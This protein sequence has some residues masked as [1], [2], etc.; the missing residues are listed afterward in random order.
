MLARGGGQR[1][2]C[3]QIEGGGQNFSLS[4]KAGYVPRVGPVL[5][6]RNFRIW[7]D[8]PPAVNNEYSLT[9]KGGLYIRK[10]ERE[11]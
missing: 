8:L 5:N 10:T 1:F 11:K 2:E 3:K 9:P 4:P 7:T 6:A